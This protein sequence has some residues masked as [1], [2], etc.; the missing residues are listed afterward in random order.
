MF[1]DETFGSSAQ[2]K[3]F[4]ELYEKAN[5]FLDSIGVD[6]EDV[7]DYMYYKTFNSSIFDTNLDL[8]NNTLYN[9]RKQKQKFFSPQFPKRKINKTPSIENFSDSTKTCIHQNDFLQDEEKTDSSFHTN[10]QNDK[11]EI[12]IKPKTRCIVSLFYIKSCERG[13]K[14]SKE[15]ENE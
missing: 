6:I 14:E 15:N 10:N 2:K 13:F 12:I 4:D 1:S 5:E 11:N 8:R 7:N 3:F 9:N